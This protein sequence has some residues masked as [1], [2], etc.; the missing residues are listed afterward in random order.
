VRWAPDGTPL[1][2]AHDDLPLEEVVEKMSK[3]RGNVISPDDV[4]AEFGADSMR[5]YELFMGPLEKG[6]PWATD[7]IPGCFRFLQRA[8]RLFLDEDAPGEPARALAEGPGTPEQERLTARTIAGVT[9]DMEATQPNTA[10]SKLMVWSREIAKDAPLP[11]AMGEAFLKLLS[12]FA[13]HL[14]EELW[15]RL[16]HNTPVALSDWPAAD[17]RWLVEETVTLVVQVNG[18]RRGE[19]VVP[20]DAGEDAVRAAALAD[21]NVL[22]HLEGKH[23][24]KVI[25]VPGRLVNVVV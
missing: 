8:H 23:P 20:K 4:I 6:A 13:P 10:I 24:R 18:K 21:E 19:V 7:G 3:S 17:A 12:P 1:H 15:E 11:R 16:G 14:A 5:L 25:V 2:P 9:A 22:R